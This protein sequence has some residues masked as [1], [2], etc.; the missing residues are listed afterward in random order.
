MASKKQRERNREAWGP[1]LERLE[2]ERERA[3]EMGGPEKVERLMHGRGKLDVR[4]RLERLFD[5][6][7]FSELGRLVGNKTEF[8]A[9]GYVCGSGLI[10]GRPAMAGAEDFTIQAGSSGSGGHYKRYRIAELAVQEGIPL[11]YLLEGAGARMGKRTGTPAR[12]PNDLEPMADAKG[13]VPTVC[14]VRG[15]TGPMAERIDID[16]TPIPDQRL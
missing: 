13:V 12:T 15:V 2:R 5:P 14:L 8:P 1:W 6:G 9:D 4:Q 7:T 11:V 3:L 10:E 16:D